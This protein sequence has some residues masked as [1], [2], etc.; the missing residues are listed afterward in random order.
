MTGGLEMETA[1]PTRGRRR[2]RFGKARWDAQPTQPAE[3]LIATVGVS[4]PRA[5][6]RRARDL[7]GGRP[8][9]VLS[10]ARM[11][12]SSL[13]MPNPGLLPSKKE[14]SEQLGFVS[15]AIDKLERSG[16]ESWGQVATTRRYAKT[17]GDAA[18]AHG[19]AHV[20]VVASTAPRWRQMVEG[21]TA[22]DVKRRIGREAAVEG[23]AV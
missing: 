10:I 15:E 11:Y 14:M 19:V 18:R 13:G 17:I 4:I 7:S 12:G 1:R 5:V 16:V 6:I 22:R 9:A 2:R 21:D 8:V 23:I 20:L 3:V